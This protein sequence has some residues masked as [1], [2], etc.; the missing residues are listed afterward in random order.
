MAK[1]PDLKTTVSGFRSAEA[2]TE[3]FQTIEEHFDGFL[4][5]DGS[6]P[7]TMQSDFD[8]NGNDILNA[9]T[10]NT[11]E[12]YVGGVK[13]VDASY[14]PNW[15]GA[16]TT[17]TDYTVNDTV[18]QDGSVYIC[19]VSHTSGTFSTDL[20]S[21]YWELFASKGSA[22]AGTGDMLAANNLSDVA[23][24]A[25]AR[26]NL[27]LGTASVENTVPLTKGGTGATTA[28]D[29]RTNLGLG[30]A[31]T[32]ALVDEDDMISNSATSVPS[33][34]SVK[35][36]ADGL[37]SSSGS[38]PFYACRAWVVFNGTGTPTILA[39]GNVSSITDNGVGDY[40]INFTTA[41]PTANYAV[42]VQAQFDNT[43]ANAAVPV[44]G[45]YRSSTSMSTSSVRIGVNESTTGNAWDATK[46]TVA[47]FA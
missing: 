38:A 45:I 43:E 25:T 18:R 46:I 34:Q 19:L 42:S 2:L 30:T 21:N 39:S 24:V 35:A 37:I 31:A 1:R 12:L 22:G 13:V 29:A 33:Q 15:E 20:T 7:N 11:D 4:S 44:T 32:A 8:L 36:Y 9:R 16:W 14:V 47:V 28:S 27:G 23:N 10:T 5:L 40:T 41:M 6:T 26:T 17:G 3:N